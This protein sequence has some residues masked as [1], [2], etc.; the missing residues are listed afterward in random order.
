MS[1]LTPDAL[2]EFRE[3]GRADLALTA[4]LVV[5]LA[6]TAVHPA[7]LAVGGALAGLLAPTL[8]RAL[9][10]GVGFGLAVLVA[11]ALVLLWYGTLLAVATAF[12]LVYI[13]VGSGLLVPPLAAVAVRGLV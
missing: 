7:G 13:A 1:V 8:R 3:T 11:W 2:A 5:G 9:V 4:A 10:L 12:P 6:A